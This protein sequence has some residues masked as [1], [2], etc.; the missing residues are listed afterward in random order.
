MLGNLKFKFAPDTSNIADLH[1]LSNSIISK[2]IYNLLSNKFYHYFIVQIIMY[3]FKQ[4]YYK[5]HLSY[6][7]F[8]HFIR[9]PGLGISSYFILNPYS[10]LSLQQ[11]PHVVSQ[12]NGPQLAQSQCL[13]T[14]FVGFRMQGRAVKHHTALPLT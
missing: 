5:I 1:F 6:K 14:G 7:L 3:F 10:P 13:R 12:Q 11:R 4:T 2:C 8:S 9:S